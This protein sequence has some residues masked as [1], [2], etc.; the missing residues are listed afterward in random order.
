MDSKSFVREY[1]RLFENKSYKAGTTG[2]DLFRDAITYWGSFYRI[3][4]ESDVKDLINEHNY[5]KQKYEKDI[6]SF[7]DDFVLDLVKA[8]SDDPK[9]YLGELFQAIGAN[10]KR[11]GQFYTPSHIAHLMS[12]ITIGDT[13]FSNLEEPK[14]FYDPTCGSGSLLIGNIKTLKSKDVNYAKDV[15]MYANDID[16]TACCMCYLQLNLLGAAAVVTQ[17]NSLLNEVQDTMPTLAM[18]LKNILSL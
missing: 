13:D 9:D 18:V 8:L 6:L 4:I 10:N 3:K 12:D 14:T 7:F 2:R 11:L 15:I 1:A 16:R 17:G 5:I